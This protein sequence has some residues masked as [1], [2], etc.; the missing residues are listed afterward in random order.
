LTEDKNRLTLGTLLSDGDA[1]FSEGFRKSMP[2]VGIQAG[3]VVAA[4]EIL[5][6]GVPGADDAG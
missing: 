2:R 1:K 6:E 4:A 5:D 3:F